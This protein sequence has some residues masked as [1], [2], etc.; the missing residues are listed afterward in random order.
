MRAEKTQPHQKGEEK[1]SLENLAQSSKQEQER[2]EFMEGQS[3][4]LRYCPCQP[5][6]LAHENPI[7]TKK[8]THYGWNQLGATLTCTVL[9]FDLIKNFK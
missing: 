3:L 4:F 8:K 7:Q 6:L 9:K 5:I 1:T 2:S